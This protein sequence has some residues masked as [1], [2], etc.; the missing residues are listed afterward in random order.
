MNPLTSALG[1]ER[2]N[3]RTRNSMLIKA[4]N[5]GAFTNHRSKT[6]CNRSNRNA[7]RFV[8]AHTELGQHERTNGP[9][10][11]DTPSIDG[12]LANFIKKNTLSRYL[13]THGQIFPLTALQA[14][15]DFTTCFY[16]H[17]RPSNGVLQHGS[18][19]V[20]FLL[21]IHSPWTHGFT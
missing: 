21:S 13:I 16:A 14:Q 7:G 8:N 12:P 17:H 18:R 20:C 2:I 9:H 1:C 19:M 15:S 11:L 6:L 5:I 10:V 4:S 3:Q